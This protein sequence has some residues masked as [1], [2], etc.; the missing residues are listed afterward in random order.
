M[1]HRVANSLQIIV[2]ILMMKTRAVVSDETREHMRDAH[3]RVMSVATVQALL[4]ASDGI[5]QI[6]AGA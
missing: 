4:H 1:E 2:S 6:A 3:D 5:E